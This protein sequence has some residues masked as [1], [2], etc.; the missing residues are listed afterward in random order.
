MAHETA[1]RAT[2][3]LAE[4]RSYASRGTYT[5]G[6]FRVQRLEPAIAPEGD[7]VTCFAALSALAGALD[8][9][10]PAD[11][12]TAL[13][14]IANETL[15]YQPAAD[16]IIGEGVRLEVAGSGQGSMAPVADAAASGEGLRI[17]TGRDQYTATDAAALRHPEA[18]QLHRY[19]HVQVSE[20]D[21]ERL[22]IS[23]EDEVELTDG[24]VTLR[25]PATVTDR[26]P[27]GAVYVSSLLQGG[28]VVGFFRGAAVPTVRV[29]VPVPA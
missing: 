17:I 27:E 20:E 26:V 12:E 25:A 19:D 8:V 7:A 28:A 9:D 1:K 16:L 11:P 5:Q 15:A 14:A 21:A 13:A 2:A 22:G 23:D 3:V 18:E 6:D 24:E 10:V 29:G 4:G